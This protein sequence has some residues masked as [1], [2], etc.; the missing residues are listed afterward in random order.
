[1]PVFAED[2]DEDLDEAEDEDIEDAFSEARRNRTRGRGYNKPRIE[3]SFATQAQLEAMSQRI[4]KDVRAIDTKVTAL[5]RTT[6]RSRGELNQSL[7]MMTMLPLLTKKTVTTDVALGTSVPAGTRLVVDDGDLL[8]LLLPMMLLN[9]GGGMLSN[10][11]NGGYGANQA[12][13]GMDM[14][15]MLVVLAASGGLGKGR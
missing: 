15:M 14:T 6:R 2:V 3:K 5:D 11:T 9:P 1:M 8:S 12:Q 10:G 13:G 7:Q 4:G